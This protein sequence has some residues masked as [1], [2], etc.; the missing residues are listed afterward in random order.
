LG[1]PL[2]TKK[3]QQLLAF[4]LAEF[5][6]TN[7]VPHEKCSANEVHILTMQIF[8]VPKNL[9]QQEFWQHLHLHRDASRL[10]C[11]LNSYSNDFN[12]QGQDL[13]L[14]NGIV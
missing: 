1:S 4:F 13:M 10:W 7:L 6:Y 5:N 11:I 12:L 3:R 8:A 9:R 2:P 14:S